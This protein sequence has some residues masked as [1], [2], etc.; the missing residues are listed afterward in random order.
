MNILIAVMILV[1]SK[2]FVCYNVLPPIHLNNSKKIT[3]QTFICL[4]PIA[5]FLRKKVRSL[6]KE[7]KAPQITE[8]YLAAEASLNP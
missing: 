3:K 4:S 7:M 5:A 8:Y 1:Q 2:G 6:F